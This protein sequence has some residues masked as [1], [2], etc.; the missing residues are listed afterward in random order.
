VGLLDIGFLTLGLVR[1]K[2]FHGL[3]LTR[4]HLSRAE[5]ERAEADGNQLVVVVVVVVCDGMAESYASF[6]VC[7]G[8]GLALKAHTHPA[9]KAQENRVTLGP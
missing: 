2:I 3:D 8:N 7:D 4:T 6:L 1:D 5:T 9:L